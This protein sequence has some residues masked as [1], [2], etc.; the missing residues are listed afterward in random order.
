M[1]N[2]YGYIR[3]ADILLIPSLSEAAPLVIGE[4]AALGV[5]VL[6]TET[7]SAHEMVEQSGY[8]WVCENSE[9]GI[10]QGIE[11]LLDHSAI[12]REK[13]KF[14]LGLSLNN[15]NAREQFMELIN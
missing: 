14:L 3:A 9:E 15:I 7:T 8:G 4:A 5:P 1:D 10:R 12:V 6:T 2:P 11:Y 13:K